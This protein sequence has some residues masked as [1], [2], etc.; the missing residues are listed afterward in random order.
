VLDPFMLVRIA[1]DHPDWRA[2]FIRQIRR[3]RFTKV[4]LYY[5]VQ[6]GDTWWELESL[7]TPIATAIARNYRLAF[8]PADPRSEG[9]YV[10]VPVG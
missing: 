7:G 9:Y 10:Y 1:R 8:T 6:P 4:V 5:R 3:R 2:E